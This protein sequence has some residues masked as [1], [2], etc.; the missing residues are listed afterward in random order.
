MNFDNYKFRCSALGKL[1]TEPKLKADKE[2]GNLSQTAT[3]YLN[4]IY[5]REVYGRYEDFNSKYTDKGNLVEEDSITLY[6]K[7]TDELHLKNETTFQN[8][9]IIGTPDLLTE[10]QVIDLKSSWSI[11]TY[12]KAD[13]STN[14]LYQ[15]LG[16]MWLTCKKFSILAYCLNN[17]P[18][19]MIQDEI[20]KLGWKMPFV[21]QQNDPEFLEAEAQIRHNMI[22]DDI[23]WE[24]RIK[25]FQVPY[26]ESFEETIKSKIIKAREYLNELKLV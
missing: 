19:Y 14:Y 20:R 22:F 3:E 25:C 12:M 18:E 5:I 15:L 13:V 8:D 17:T 23:P 16:Y 7:F 11:W 10:T 6:S 9:F 21:D 4:A 26:D 2:A 1:M 24:D